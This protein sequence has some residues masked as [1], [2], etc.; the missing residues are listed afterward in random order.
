MA[1]ST[2][3]SRS[4]HR[5]NPQSRRPQTIDHEPIRIVPLH[6][7]AGLAPAATPQLTYRNGPLIAA[8]EVFTIFWGAAWKQAPQSALIGQLN[9][10]F[11]FVLTSPLIDQ[12]AEYNV[13]D[14]TISY[15]SRTGPSK[16]ATTTEYQP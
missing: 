8:V 13:Q 12:L 1:K 5:T 10:F 14:Y 16:C 7:P 4:A 11:D 2:R 6:V 3:R 9:T 15:G